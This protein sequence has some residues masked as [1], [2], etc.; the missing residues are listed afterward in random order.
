M[1][2]YILQENYTEY[3]PE[4]GWDDNGSYDEDVEHRDVIGV[5]VTLDDAVR[6]LVETCRMAK[7]L[8]LDVDE[9]RDYDILVGDTETTEVRS[10]L[11]KEYQELLVKIS[12]MK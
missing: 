6:K 11:Y 7:E 12:C 8:D 10:V 1:K 5:F 2:V 9:Y 3:V 4:A